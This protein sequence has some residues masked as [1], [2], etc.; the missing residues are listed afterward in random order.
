MVGNGRL[1]IQQYTDFIQAARA[2]TKTLLPLKVRYIFT[3]Q[4]NYA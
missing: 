2:G 4:L 3:N 1:T